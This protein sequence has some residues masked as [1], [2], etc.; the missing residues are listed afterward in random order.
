MMYSNKRKLNFLLFLAVCVF[1]SVAATK[2]AAGIKTRTTVND[3]GLF[4]NLKVLP[5][6]ISKQ[7]LDTIM[8]GFNKALAVHC[9]FCHAPGADGKMD[10]S[11]D[12]KPE[13]DIARYMFTMTAEIN[14][15]YFNSENSTRPD[16]ISVVKCLTCHHGSPHP[17]EAAMPADNHGNMPPPDRDSSGKMPPPPPDH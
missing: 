1:I 11:S 3:T 2:P 6:D 13:K 10:F 16:T 12:A 7:E 14:T 4:K 9:N 5:K 17:D 8:H 15:K